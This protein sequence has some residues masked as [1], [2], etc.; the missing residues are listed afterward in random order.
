MENAGF[1]VT[2]L[3]SFSIIPYTIIAMK[4]TNDHLFSIK[5]N[6]EANKVKG[7]V[8]KWERRHWVRTV[9]G[10]IVFGMAVFKIGQK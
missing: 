7:I 4:P 3:L 1:L 10:A 9:V 6:E 8:R 2:A 5:D